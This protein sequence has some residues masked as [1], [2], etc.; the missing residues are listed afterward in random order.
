VIS[1]AA[2]AKDVEANKVADRITAC[3]ADAGNRVSNSGNS[4][5]WQ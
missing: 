2:F 4:S 3:I 1:R 5:L